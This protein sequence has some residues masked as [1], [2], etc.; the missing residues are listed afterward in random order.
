MLADGDAKV[1]VEGLEDDVDGVAAGLARV[2][3]GA[4]AEVLLLGDGGVVTVTTAGDA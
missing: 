3:L 2:G 1:A 4:G